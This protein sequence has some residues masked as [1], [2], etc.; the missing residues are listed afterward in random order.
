MSP[1]LFLEHILLVGRIKLYSTPIRQALP[2]DV[3][4]SSCRIGAELDPAY[5]TTGIVRPLTTTAV[6]F[7]HFRDRF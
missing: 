2:K 4:Y 5:F 7:L 3:G 6:D 1:A